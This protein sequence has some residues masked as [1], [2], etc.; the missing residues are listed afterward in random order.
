[1]GA[2][3]TPTAPDA[4]RTRSP[5]NPGAVSKPVAAQ[6][7]HKAPHHRFSDWEVWSYPDGS[8]QYYSKKAE[9]T[10]PDEPKRV[11]LHDGWSQHV[12]SANRD[13][14]LIYQTKETMWHQP[15]TLAVNQG[16]MPKPGA[17]Q[18][19]WLG[20]MNNW[21]GSMN[22]WMGSMSGIN[23]WMKP[24][25][26]FNNMPSNQPQPSVPPPRRRSSN[27]NRMQRGSNVT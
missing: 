26:M 15:G 25:D 11:N 5:S 6:R 18:T 12:D 4:A 24:M 19:G 2:V 13:Y 7:V 1:M 22:N 9:V 3:S 20:G 21:M 10:V 16:T 17:T 27:Q 14:Y 23:N 8:I